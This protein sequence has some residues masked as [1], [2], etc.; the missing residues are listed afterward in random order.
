M[1][2]FKEFD[3]KNLTAKIPHYKNEKTGQILEP[4]LI[5]RET[6]EKSKI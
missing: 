1:Y 6:R 4:P 2:Y 3:S 5:P